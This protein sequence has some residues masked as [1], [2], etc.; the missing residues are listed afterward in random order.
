MLQINHQLHSRY[1]L[2]VKHLIGTRTLFS[3]DPNMTSTQAPSHNQRFSHRSDNSLPSAPVIAYSRGPSSQRKFK[4]VACGLRCFHERNPDSQQAAN[5]KL[6]GNWICPR[7]ATRLW[8]PN[9]QPGA[10]STYSRTSSV[11]G[12]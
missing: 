2:Q 12:H 7:D 5:S 11:I 9:D 1:I 4:R 6:I 3:S 10:D 8:R